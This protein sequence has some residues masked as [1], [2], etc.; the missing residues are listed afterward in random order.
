MQEIKIHLYRYRTIGPRRGEQLRWRAF[1]DD[2]SVDVAA[3]TRVEVLKRFARQAGFPDLRETW[4]RVRCVRYEGIAR[5][6]EVAA[7]IADI[8][9]ATRRCP[10]GEMSIDDCAGECGRLK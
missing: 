2:A 7:H 8:K 4:S 9:M 10:C 5:M 1:S 3:E 6:S